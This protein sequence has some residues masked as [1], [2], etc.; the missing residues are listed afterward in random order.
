MRSPIILEIRQLKIQGQPSLLEKRLSRHIVT[1]EADCHLRQGTITSTTLKELY[2]KEK[3]L[4]GWTKRR[5]KE[6]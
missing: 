6:L 2:N 3:T 4:S 5:R 1:L